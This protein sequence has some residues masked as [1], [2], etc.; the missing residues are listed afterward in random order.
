[1]DERYNNISLAND[2]AMR[3]GDFA[4]DMAVPLLNTSNIVVYP[5]VMTSIMI[6]DPMLVAMVQK[7]MTT[8]RQIGVF[9]ELPDG[10]METTPEVAEADL[11][12]FQFGD[13]K[14][15]K[16]GCLARITKVLSFPDGSLRILVRGLRRVVLNAVREDAARGCYLAVFSPQ[17]SGEAD[18]LEV[19][20]AM[21]LIMAKFQELTPFLAG[22]PEELRLAVLNMVDPARQIDLLTD[23]LNLTYLERLAILAAPSLYD[24]AK[25]MLT[26]VNR[27]SEIAQLGQ[28]IQNEVNQNLSQQQREYFLRE[29]LRTIQ[30]ELNEDTRTPDVIDLENRLKELDAPEQVLTTIQRELGRLTVLPQMSPEYHIAY[31]YI[32]WLLSLP[33]RINSET[34]LDIR[35]AQKVLDADHYG[36]KDVK[37]RILDYLAVLQMRKDGKAPILC[38]VGP[39]GVGKTSLGQSIARAM[40]RKFVRMALGGMHDEAEIRGH[41]RTYVGALPGRILQSMKKVGVNNPVFMLDEIDKINSDMR[42]DPASALLEVLDPAQNGAFNDHYIELDYDLSSVFFIAT[43]NVMDTIPEPLLDR[44]E[45]IRLPGYTGTEKRQ[46]AKRFLVARQ[47]KDNGLSA[48][49]LSF[50]VKAL[51]ELVNYYTREAGVRDL[52]RTIG[53]VCRKVARRIL[54]GEIAA[55]AK[56]E[57][58]PELIHDLLGGRK[59]MLDLVKERPPRGSAVGMAWTSYGG[60][61]LTVETIMMPGK[62]NLKLTG[63][64][65]N[66]MKE[67]AEAAFSYI[68]SRAKEFGVKQEVFEQ[69]D[70]HIHVPDGATPKD[71]PSAGI[72]LTTALVS[73]L[74]GKR[75]RPRLSMTGEITLAGKVTAIGGLKEKCVAAL[76]AGVKT[77]IMP[78]ENEKDLEEV[79]DEV[80]PHLEFIMVDTITEALPIIFGEKTEEHKK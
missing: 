75:V 14:L 2:R 11:P 9:P 25:L 65:G 80:K 16:V 1:M 23:A 54:S 22:L 62:G 45:V 60:A 53:A 52:E 67:S 46:I 41:R 34:T 32:D 76:R 70:F 73:L 66:V 5:F 7:V 51:D 15:L 28:H 4:A 40:G 48:K 47:I 26:L 72:T 12:P 44:M 21:K 30:T 38:L 78:R 61:I 39:P 19:S 64:L 55:D 36:L 71:G 50:P 10:N 24:R 63:S 69:N 37:E 18:Q 43:A 56:T 42:G 29:Q 33:W 3:A 57:I 68:R 77:V 35:E 49:Q 20:A 8:D 59:Y 79:P 74:T 27:E 6:D 31:T 13:R 17:V 58:T